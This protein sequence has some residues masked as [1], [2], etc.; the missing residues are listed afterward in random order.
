MAVWLS[1][2]YYWCGY[3]DLGWFG[4]YALQIRCCCFLCTLVGWW[5]LVWF[6]TIWACILGFVLLLFGL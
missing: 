1:L 2:C 6:V 3:V 5:S 4:G